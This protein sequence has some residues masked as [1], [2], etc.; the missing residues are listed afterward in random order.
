[1]RHQ[2]AISAAFAR[3]GY[4]G[5][6]A[7][8]HDLAVRML[9]RSR[10]DVPGAS[11][12]AGAVVRGDAGMLM[13][14]MGAD[15]ERRL[16]DYVRRVAA[17]MAGPAAPKSPETGQRETTAQADVDPAPA[18]RRPVAGGEG[19]VIPPSREDIE[20]APSPPA[21]DRSRAGQ[22]TRPAQ[23]DKK[24]IP[25]RAPTPSIRPGQG[26]APPRGDIHQAPA[27][28]R[29]HPGHARRGAA[30]MAGAQSAI[31]R[32]LFDTY[33]IDGEPIGTMTFGMARRVARQKGIEHHVLS[34]VCDHVQAPDS[35][36][37]REA[38]REETLRDIIT[39]AT[40][41]QDGG[42]R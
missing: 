40:A 8:L 30:A 25:A 34:A 15:L 9:R 36:T 10:G 4:D 24:S 16:E 39:A 2:N 23:A 37:I 5:A 7:R 21:P 33:L 32:S 19:Q 1:M 31:A 6:A 13:A 3:A 22:P 41:P 42:A 27:P 38:L 20:A 18:L 14:L 28:D 12:D 17:D 35:T 29:Y 26:V 11:R